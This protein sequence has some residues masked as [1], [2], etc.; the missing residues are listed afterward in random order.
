MEKTIKN[1][2]LIITKTFIS[3][4]LV[5]LLFYRFDFSKIFKNQNNVNWIILIIPVILIFLSQ[6]L[7]AYKWKCLLSSNNTIS[8]FKLFKI[9]LIGYFFNNFFPSG[10][11]GDSYKIYATHKKDT[12]DSYTSVFLNRITGLFALYL[13][14]LVSGF[15]S[16]SKM[17]YI[18]KNLFFSVNIVTFGIIILVVILHK[19]FMKMLL[20]IK[21]LNSLISC[22][23]EYFK[24]KN[25]N[26]IMFSKVF[27]CSLL[28]Q[29]LFIC[30]VMLYFL[31][32]N[33]N[34]SFFNAA[35]IFSFISIA[36][37]LPVTLNGWGINENMYLYLSFELF[38]LPVNPIIAFIPRIP[39][40]IVSIISGIYYMIVTIKS[41]KS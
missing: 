28:I 31:I 33:I 16:L 9:N 2:I 12:I 5:L 41:K 34:I 35:I 32:V 15:F 29:C 22:V 23:G 36:M 38:F 19:T 1:R 20:R 30:N 11:G 27:L 13:I 21:K 39:Q 6:F 8:L 14:F 40:F 18:L 37:L 3:C 17:D 24:D 10:I 4:N 25:F 7:N 26:S